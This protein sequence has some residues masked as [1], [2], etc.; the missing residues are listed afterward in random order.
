MTLLSSGVSESHRYKQATWV[1]KSRADFK[2]WKRKLHDSMYVPSS[3]ALSTWY[4]ST[5]TSSSPVRPTAGSW[6]KCHVPG[7]MRKRKSLSRAQTPLCPRIHREE[8]NWGESIQ[9][10]MI[11][12]V[13]F[14]R[15]VCFYFNKRI[16]LLSLRLQNPVRGKINRNLMKWNTSHTGQLCV[17][18]LVSWWSCWQQT[19]EDK[20]IQCHLLRS[21]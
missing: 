7:S 17:F 6:I 14:L 4:R 18:H 9:M 20:E 3:A 5:F 2:T 8:L 19:S 21:V 15:L 16:L 12:T 11:L 1:S 10:D 13:V